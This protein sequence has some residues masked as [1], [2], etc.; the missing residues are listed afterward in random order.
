MPRHS[1]TDGMLHGFQLWINLPARDKMCKPRYQD[2][3]A[4]DIPVAS[5]EGVSVR[6]MAG[7]WRRLWLHP[8]RRR[9]AAPR[10]QHQHPA[11]P[12]LAASRTQAS[13]WHHGPRRP[14]THIPGPHTRPAA[15]ESLGASGPIKMRNPGM[16]LD[17][18]VSKGGSFE[19]PVGP[20]CWAP[21]RARQQARR[22]QA[23]PGG[24]CTDQT[25]RG[26]FCQ[27]PGPGPLPRGPRLGSSSSWLPPCL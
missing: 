4:G 12:L 17:V 25:C 26:S 19:Q 10:P 15:G 11:S 7:G 16:L 21:A 13:P 23:R 3:Q 27:P 2:Y 24:S 8:R 22:G 18:R 6:V 1:S 5:A 20:S 14:A 9:L